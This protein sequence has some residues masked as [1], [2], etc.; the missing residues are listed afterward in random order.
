MSVDNKSEFL[1]MN[2]STAAHRLRKNILFSLV[3][4]L[5]RNVCFRCGDPIERSEDLSI[6]HK[7]FW[8]YT[9][10]ELFWDLDNITFSH[11]KCNTLHRRHPNTSKK[12]CIRG[13][14]FTKENTY[15]RK[16]NE[17]I[18]KTCE[19]VAKKLRMRKL[20]ARRRS[21]TGRAVVS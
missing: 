2:Y 12:E 18:C 14:A 9:D 8:L 11:L 19:R 4:E 1:G 16:N 5:G 20:R 6:E 21:S 7:E 13:H 10:P 17:R 15:V 3:Q